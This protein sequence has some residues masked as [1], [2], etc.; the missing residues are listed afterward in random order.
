MPRAGGVHRPM[1]DI[2]VTPMV[3]VMLVLLVI[4][5]VTAPLMQQGVDVDLP[6]TTSQPLTVS[7]EPLILSVKKDGRYYVGRKELPI[8]ELRAKLEAIFEGRDSKEL[9]LRADAEAPYGLVVKA[10]A[11]AREAGAKSLGMVTEPES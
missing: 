9:F 2:N 8:E 4:F 3:D 6:E 7:D 11:A 1:A 5:M 10:L